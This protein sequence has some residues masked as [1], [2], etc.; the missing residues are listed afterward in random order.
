[1]K[2][3]IKKKKKGRSIM[4]KHHKK[5][6]SSKKGKTSTSNDDQIKTKT[7]RDHLEPENVHNMNDKHRKVVTRTK[8]TKNQKIKDTKHSN[9]K[10]TNSKS[11]TPAQNPSH[12]S[13]FKD[14]NDNES[15]N[16]IKYYVCMAKQVNNLH[17]NEAKIFI[18][19]TPIS[20]ILRMNRKEYSCSLTELPTGEKEVTEDTS[21][22]ECEKICIRNDTL[23][24][25]VYSN[26][27]HPKY[28]IG[29][30]HTNKPS[31]DTL[32][33]PNVQSW[34]SNVSIFNDHVDNKKSSVWE[35]ELIVGK[36]TM[37]SA[38]IFYTAWSTESRGIESKRRRC[39]DLYFKEVINNQNLKCFDKRVV[40]INPPIDMWLKIVKLEEFIPPPVYVEKLNMV[41]N[42]IVSNDREKLIVLN[43]TN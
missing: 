16:E 9:K 7:E 32:T 35:P 22:S 28:L 1:M 40:P 43:Y 33:E 29:D 10:K 31:T 4:D 2:V 30:N 23:G 8:N 26:R 42:E 12:T 39:L 20:A 15:N 37:S 19:E 36:F 13:I 25:D 5:H 3:D 34:I 17:K 6:T 18:S 38:E 11:E 41:L 21:D 27:Y 14:K 24:C